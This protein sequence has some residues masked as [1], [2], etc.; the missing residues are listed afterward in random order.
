M[1]A[2]VCLSAVCLSVCLCV[3]L[4]VCLSVC[5]SVSQ[6]FPFPF[7]CL[8][9]LNNNY[10]SV[11]MS[12]CLCLLSPC[13][14]PPPTFPRPLS[15]L[16]LSP[17][18]HLHVS[19]SP[20]EAPQQAPAPLAAAAVSPAAPVPPVTTETC[21][22]TQKGALTTLTERGI[23]HYNNVAYNLI[24]TAVTPECDTVTAVTCDTDTAFTIGR[25]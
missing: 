6:T 24:T 21:H 9:V 7:G 18:A 15:C 14:S 16:S 10:L 17:L 12:Y 23:D 4:S 1:R 22:M 2:C 13:V 3:C 8:A 25:L 20:E 11:S 5:V 19:P